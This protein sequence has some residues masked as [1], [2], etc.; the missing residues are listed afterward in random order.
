MRVADGYWSCDPRR[1]GLLA[2][3]GGSSSAGDAGMALSAKY[4]RLLRGVPAYGEAS[5]VL[6]ARYEVRINGRLSDRA[7]GALSAMDVT[8]VPRGRLC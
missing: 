2:D 4:L 8:P 5:A 1:Q 6:H 3:Q 7:G